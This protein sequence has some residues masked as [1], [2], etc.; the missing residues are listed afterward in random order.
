MLFANLREFAD[1][2]IS[3]DKYNA[4]SGN[5]SELADAIISGDKYK[6]PS[7]L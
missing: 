1:A 3:G 4:P 6:L 5:L 2:I 7:D